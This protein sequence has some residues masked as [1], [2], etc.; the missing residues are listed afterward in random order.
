VTLAGIS[1]E[2]SEDSVKQLPSI[3]PSSEPGSNVQAL[4]WAFWKQPRHSDRTVRGMQM[5]YSWHSW[6]QCASIA[7][8][9]DGDSNET[10]SR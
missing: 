4:I 7:V 6:K 8:S 3:W 9:R 1:I 5:N 10:N 2:V